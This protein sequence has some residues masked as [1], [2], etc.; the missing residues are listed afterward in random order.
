MERTMI[1][2][3]ETRELMRGFLGNNFLCDHTFSYL[4][5]YEEEVLEIDLHAHINNCISS[6]RTQNYI[7][8]RGMV[9]YLKYFL[10]NN[11][12]FDYTENLYH[13]CKFC[14]EYN[15]HYP[16]VITLFA[17]S[18]VDLNKINSS[19]LPLIHTVLKS[20][21]LLDWTLASVII[22]CLL[23]NGADINLLDS[24]GR[25]ILQYFMSMYKGFS[26][27][28]KTVITFLIDK[29]VE[30]ESINVDDYGWNKE[31]KEEYSAYIGSKRVKPAK[32]AINRE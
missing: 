8:Y 3:I 13:I 29:G 17:D 30:Y 7:R 25:N 9:N 22:T 1:A 2:R 6:L 18:G 12:S 11:K 10:Q 19:G 24:E 31:H 20:K 32:C 23:E 14:S 16:S 5:D 26:T 27:C 21:F 15:Y 4:L 28:Y